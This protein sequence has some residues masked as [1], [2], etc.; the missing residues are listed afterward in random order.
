MPRMISSSR[1]ERA[2]SRSRTPAFEPAYRRLRSEAESF[3]TAAAPLQPPDATA[4]FY[5]DYFCPD[6]ARQLGF[7]PGRPLV[8]VCPEDGRE[9]TGEPYDAAWRWFVNNRLSTM[10]FRLALLWRLD[11]DEACRA[12]A[13]EILSGYARRYPRYEGS[14]P[15]IPKT[16]AGRPVG[17]GRATFQSLDEAVWLI[18][19]ARAYDLL[20][21]SLDAGGRRQIESGLLRPAAEHLLRQR[22]LEIHNIECWHNAAIA[23]VS[24]C[25]DEP[26]WQRQTL[27]GE[28]GFW[29]QLA[30]GVDDDGLWWEGSS[31]YH[32]YTVAALVTQALI[33]ESADASLA[34]PASRLETMFGAAIQLVQ[35]DGR[36]PATNDCWFSSSLLGDVCHGVPPA[37]ALYE[38]AHAWYG[39]PRFAWLLRQNYAAGRPRDSIEA[40]LYGSELPAPRAAV[41]FGS[42]R[43]PDAGLTQLRS[44][45]PLAAQTCVLLKHGPHGGSHGHPDKLAI[46]FYSGGHPTSPDLGTP[47]YGIALNDSWFRQTL[48]HNTVVVDGH[49]QPPAQGAVAAGRG[50]SAPSAWAAA[51]AHVRWEREPYAGVAMRRTILQCAA[52]DYF[53]DVFTVACDRERTLDWV[54]RVDGDLLGTEGLAAGRPVPLSGDGYEHVDAA[55]FYAPARSATTAGATPDARLDWQ[56][57]EAHLSVFLPAETGTTT[58]VHGRVPHNPTSRTSDIL[59]R[60]RPASTTTFV[61]L[62][63]SWRAARRVARVEPCELTV[64]DGALALWV[65]LVDD[66]RHLVTLSTREHVASLPAPAPGDRVYRYIL[67]GDDES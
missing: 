11:G 16:R 13:H 18:P 28:F 5:H 7:D 49:S 12:R 29:R 25:L 43:L 30:D 38:I 39:D 60:R 34:A 48:S 32:F 20:G 45:D 22:F 67:D 14:Q 62:F 19:L 36:L 63:H 3:L 15:P 65:Y 47:G 26:A 33:L 46:S 61:T 54:C 42:G 44:T 59:L 55:A 66:G 40:L 41:S 53:V 21:E 51:D 52:A 64:A 57:P 8:H 56:L 27:D 4:G 24:L 37:A 50:D 58:L 6:H 9:F 2:R 23:A 1:L 10:A 31:S 17:G 35:P